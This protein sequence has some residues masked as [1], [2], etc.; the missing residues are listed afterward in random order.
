MDTA[1]THINRFPIKVINVFRD[2]T[3]VSL[4]CM[5]CI[6][7]MLGKM[8]FL[9]WCYYTNSIKV[10][11]MPSL[12]VINCLISYSFSVKFGLLKDKFTVNLNYIANIPFNFVNCI[13]NL[14]LLSWK[15][16]DTQILLKNLRFSIRIP[17]P[18]ILL[19]ETKFLFTWRHYNCL[20]RVL[21]WLHYFRA[22]FQ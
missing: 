21:C 17:P 18:R 7:I 6:V 12:L 16:K 19:F 22:R 10:K 9:D 20:E 2:L 15:K 14:E 11:L 4:L 13:I 3:P 8:H 5:I 1:I